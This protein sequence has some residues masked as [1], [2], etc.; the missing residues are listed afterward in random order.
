MDV[1]EWTAKDVFGLIS[2]LIFTLFVIIGL[3]WGALALHRVYNVWAQYKEGEAEL[4]KATANRQIAIQEAMAKQES[5][6]HLAEAEVIRAEGV[7][8]A[9][10]IIGNSLQNNE[11]YLRYLWIDGLHSGKNQVIYIPTEANLPILEAAKR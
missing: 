7:A 2:G 1:E 4:V 9:N 11:A 10:L 8:R 6:K 3:C 5:A